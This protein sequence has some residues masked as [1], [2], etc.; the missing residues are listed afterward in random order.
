MTVI[1]EMASRIVVLAEC[2]HDVVLLTNVCC[3]TKLGCAVCGYAAGFFLIDE[4]LEAVGE[5]AWQRLQQTCGLDER[6]L[7]GS[8]ELGSST[9]RLGQIGERLDVFGRHRLAAD[10]ST[11]DDQERVGLGCVL[12]RLGDA[13][14]IAADERDGGRADEQFGETVEACVLGAEASQRVLV[15]LVL[16]AADRAADDA[17]SPVAPTLMPRY[18]VMIAAWRCSSLAVTSST[19]ATFSARGFSVVMYTSFRF[20]SGARF[21]AN[22]ARSERHRCQTIGSRSSPRLVGEPIIP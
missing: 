18:S 13:G 1:P 20:D 21:A 5:V 16:A 22:T 3:V 4:G 2:C 8:G 6:G 14:D 10:R 15:H 9:S 17:A 19:T 12:Q 11:L 7:E